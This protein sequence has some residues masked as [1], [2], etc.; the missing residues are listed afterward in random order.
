MIGE[1]RLRVLRDL[2]ARTLGVVVEQSCQRLCEVLGQY[3]LDTP[4]SALYLN[5]TAADA[6]GADCGGST[7]IFESAR[8]IPPRNQRSA[9]CK[10]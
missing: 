3:P 2:A 6:G 9:T 1:R 5:A 7:P 10:I 8:P 4:F